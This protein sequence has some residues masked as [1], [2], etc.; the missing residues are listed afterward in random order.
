M[1]RKRQNGELVDKA[2]RMAAGGGRLCEH[3]GCEARGEFRAPRS[4]EPDDGHYVFCLDHVRAYN[5]AWDFFAGMNQDEIERY[6]RNNATWHRPTWR[7]GMRPGPL[8]GPWVRD[9]LGLLAEL[10]L[11][12][13]LGGTESA[14]ARPQD[15]KQQ[16][17]LA[18]LDLEP[19]VTLQEIKTRYKELAKR[20]HPDANGG[21]KVAEERLKEVNQAYSYLLSCGYS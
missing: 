12:F 11:Q 1:A 15:P 3:P 2:G 9:D 6:Q 16:R 18:T 4:R 17:A 5:A 13:T 21:D 7:F 19:T 8:N 10:G 14:P 20:Y